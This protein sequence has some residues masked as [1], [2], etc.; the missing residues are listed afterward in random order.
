MASESNGFGIDKIFAIF[1]V[2]VV[3]IGLVYLARYA[4]TGLTQD[5]TQVNQTYSGNSS[6]EGGDV[7]AKPNLTGKEK[8]ELS[9]QGWIS[10]SDAAW[11][12]KLRFPPTYQARLLDSREL[13]SPLSGEVI[14]SGIVVATENN[15]SRLPDYTDSALT[16][17]VTEWPG[18]GNSESF[19]N[20][21]YRSGSVPQSEIERLTIGGRPALRLKVNS[22]YSGTNGSHTEIIVAGPGARIFKILYWPSQDATLSAIANSLEIG[23]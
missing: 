20:E 4:A 5:V 14:L 19:L 7:R 18:Y 22:G 10:Y 12:Y 13:S 21:T 15:T 3:L 23:P 11:A 2:I 8:G 9:Q 17:L 1:L 6:T 16:L